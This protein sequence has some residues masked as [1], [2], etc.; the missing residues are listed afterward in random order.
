[1]I[2]NLNH[3][4]LLISENEILIRVRNVAGVSINESSHTYATVIH[5]IGFKY[6]SLFYLLKTIE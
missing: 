6:V 1:M 4:V 5:T 2:A 3:N